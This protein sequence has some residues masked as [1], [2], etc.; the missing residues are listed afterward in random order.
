M[1][2]QVAVI[3]VGSI[4]SMALWQL[5]RQGI[6]AIG[7]ERYAPG[8][9]QA[10]A[11]GESRIFRTAYLEGPQY[12]PLLVRA[13]ELWRELEQESGQSLLNLNGG[14]M[15]GPEDSDSMRNVLVSAD[16]FD[17]PHEVLDT[18]E[19]GRRYP[20]HR[21]L[22]GEIGFFDEWA[23]VLRPEF[24]VL[25][26][27]RRAQALGARVV[28]G[29]RVTAVEPFDAGVR[30][31]VGDRVYTVEQAVVTAGPWTAHFAPE[32]ARHV[33]PRKLVMTWY[34][35]L[36]VDA[37]RPERFP[38][39]IR[40]SGEV[41]IFGIPTL[42]GGSVKVAPHAPYGDL[43]DADDLDRNVAEGDLDAINRVVAELMPGLVPTPVR[44]SAYLEAY[45]TDGHALVGQLPGAE[46]VWLLGA[47]SGHGFKMASAFGQVAADLV[48]NG[49]TSL[50]IE[51]LDPA[52]FAR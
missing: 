38:I 7:F 16:R 13:R 6:D 35:A 3:G 18:A 1:D 22:P 11:G 49:K 26:A 24:A 23:G 48:A 44:V 10:A 5:A 17:L 15:I 20:Q 32:L 51:H 30:V 39:F 36:D 47:F 40:E 45:T 42:D 14:L 43:A 50:P 4:G 2:A 46:N 21:M 28:S 33:T 19:M 27:A 52:R 31:H 9:D 25:T 12:V 29:A 41:H 37:Y 8:H 34:P